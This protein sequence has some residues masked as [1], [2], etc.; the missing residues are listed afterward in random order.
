M[1]VGFKECEHFYDKG[2]SL[3][4]DLESSEHFAE[5]K[6]ASHVF[7]FSRVALTIDAAICRDEVQWMA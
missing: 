2:A 6:V 5:V 1:S 7:L 3:V 4:K